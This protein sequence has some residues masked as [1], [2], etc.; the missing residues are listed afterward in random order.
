MSKVRIYKILSQSEKDAPA[1]ALERKYAE[2][3]GRTYGEWRSLDEADRQVLRA[4]VDGITKKAARV[5]RSRERERY[6]AKESKM[7]VDEWR[8]LPS[9]KRKEKKAA[10]NARDKMERKR[11]RQEEIEAREKLRR[12]EIERAAI[13]KLRSDAQEKPSRKSMRKAPPQGLPGATR[14]STITGLMDSPTNRKWK[15]F[16]YEGPYWNYLVNFIAR[17]NIFRGRRDRVEEAAQNT[18]AKIGKFMMMKRFKYTEVGKGYF[19]GFLKRVA[20]RTAIDLFK[21][22]RRQEQIR[23]SES[24]SE[25]KLE[26]DTIHDDML[27]ARASHEKTLAA[28]KAAPGIDSEI[29]SVTERDLDVYDASAGFDRNIAPEV[30]KDSGKKMH[31]IARLDDNPFMDDEAPANYNPPDLFDYLTKVSKEDLGWVQRLQ[32]HVLYIALGYVLTNEKVSAEKR[33]MLRLR[34]G[35]DMKTKDIYALPRFASKSRNAFDVQ[36]NRATDELR[37]EVKEWWKIVAPSKNDFADETVLKIWRKLS[38]SYDRAKIAN[39]LQDKAIVRAGRI[40]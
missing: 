6:Y 34:Y 28:K 21:E 16:L 31:N 4:Q 3:V 11:R 37:K 18:C 22:I 14:L 24:K 20:F 23:G 26:D 1:E 10:I 25:G 12:E 40:K 15:D 9:V 2:L 39:D 7:S 30:K 36:M 33:E 13:E 38:N 17:K 5:V 27:K 32:I 19:R 29:E 8:N 35:L